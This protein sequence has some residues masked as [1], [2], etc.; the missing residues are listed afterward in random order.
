MTIIGGTNYAGFCSVGHIYA[1]M[2]VYG[3]EKNQNLMQPMYNKE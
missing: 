1:C 3:M 2:Y